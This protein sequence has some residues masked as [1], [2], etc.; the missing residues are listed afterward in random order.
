MRYLS[1]CVFFRTFWREASFFLKLPRDA[2]CSM[3]VVTCVS[4][5]FEWLRLAVVS[6][7]LLL[8]RRVS[9][10]FS[11]SFSFSSILRI[12]CFSCLPFLG[13]FY[14]TS[15]D[16][17]LLCAALC[18]R[19]FSC[20]SLSLSLLLLREGLSSESYRAYILPLWCLNNFL[21]CE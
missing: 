15:Y 18:L 10:F 21:L 6:F 1:L 20:F 8:W 7:F 17:S 19:G 2:L 4:L 16:L 5:I 12:S 14:C 3:T 9:I 13:G 11:N